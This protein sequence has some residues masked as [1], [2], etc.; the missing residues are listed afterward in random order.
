MSAYVASKRAIYGYLS[1]LRQ[2]YKK[3]KKNITI[4]MGCPYMVRTTM[5]EGFKTKLEF[6]LRTLDEGYVGKRLA[7][8]FVQKKE[9]CFV[10][11][12]EAMIFKLV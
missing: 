11:Q 9:V 1:S 8:E 10:Y 6:F 7:K 5:F 4:S 3:E 2:E 12:Y